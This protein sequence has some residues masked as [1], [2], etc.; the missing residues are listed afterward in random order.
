MHSMMSTP[1]ITG[2]AG[3]WPWKK[4]SLME[5]FFTPMAETFFT[6]ST[7]RSTSRKG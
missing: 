3:K 1:G 5:T 7:I 6:T 4:G 2:C